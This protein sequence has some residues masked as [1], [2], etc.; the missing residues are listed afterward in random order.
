MRKTNEQ[1]IGEVFRQMLN[2]YKLNE[3]YCDAQL[4][5]LWP[6][7]MGNIIAKETSELFLRHKK[8]YIRLQSAVLKHQLVLGRH[9]LIKLFNDELGIQ[10]IE[11]V[12][13]L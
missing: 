12:I 10:A 9:Q 6:K 7:L 4:Q 2:D 5:E 8:L 13:F 3:K 11:E 1:S